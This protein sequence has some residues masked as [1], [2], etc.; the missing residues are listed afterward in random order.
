[1]RIYRNIFAIDI[2]PDAPPPE[3]LIWLLRSRLITVLPALSM[4]VLCEPLELPP[5]LIDWA[6]LIASPIRD[7]VPPLLEDPPPAVNFWNAAMAAAIPCCCAD[8]LDA[9]PCWY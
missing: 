6:M 1:M 4:A 7:E 5:E 3:P 8:M 2:R 9:L